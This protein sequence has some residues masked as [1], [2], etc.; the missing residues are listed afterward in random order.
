LVHCTISGLAVYAKERSVMS[1]G[2]KTDFYIKS[3]NGVVAIWPAPEGRFVG[4]VKTIELHP[5]LN[6]RSSVFHKCWVF[7]DY[8]EDEDFRGFDYITRGLVVGTST[9]L[10]EF[11]SLCRR[12]GIRIDKGCAGE[13]YVPL[14]NGKRI[15]AESISTGQSVFGYEEFDILQCRIDIPIEADLL[16]VMKI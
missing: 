7:K 13:G 2:R 5:L 6:F 9:E 1:S 11:K 15:I 10:E 3:L 16:A 4:L 8:L 12:H 14:S